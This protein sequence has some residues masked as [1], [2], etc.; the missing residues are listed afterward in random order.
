MWNLRPTAMLNT[1]KVL[2]FVLLP[3]SWGEEEPAVGVAE[4]GGVVEGV[5]E[6]RGRAEWLGGGEECGLPPPLL[7][8][9]RCKVRS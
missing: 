5:G 9:C 2:I 7:N 3:L 1:I 6:T 4:P 8:H